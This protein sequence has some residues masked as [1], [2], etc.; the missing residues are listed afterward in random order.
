MKIRD[1][2]LV[3]KKF[4]FANYS[5]F[6][7]NSGY[8][9][10]HL[11]ITP[12]S[13]N[14]NESFERI[15]FDYENV[16]KKENLSKDS[17]FFSR[18]HFDNKDMDVKL[19]TDF[20]KKLSLKPC[21]VIQQPPLTGKICFYSW[22]IY[23]KKEKI[24]HLTDNNEVFIQGKNYD[25]LFNSGIKSKKNNVYLQTKDIFNQFNKRLK[26][27][28]MNFNNNFVRSWIYVADI[29]ENYESMVKARKDFFYKQGLKNFFPASTGI[30]C[31]SS[32]NSYVN[33]DF[34]SVNRIKKEQIVPI[35]SRLMPKPTLY[36]VTFERG[37]EIIFGDRK[38]I[39]ISG[40]ASIGK[41]GEVLYPDNVEKQTKVIV[42]NIKD[43]LLSCNSS[44]NDIAQMNV[45]LRNKDDYEK[46]KKIIDVEFLKNTPYLILQ[47]AVCRKDWL[48]EIDAIAIK[49]IKSKFPVLL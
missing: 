9:E 14:L 23:S 12:N 49:S 8:N 10:L 17:L 19:I 28:K 31:L 5:V 46:V 39:Y 29:D 45:Y 47:G 36:G 1:T 27:R 11:T 44:L 16:L 26:N 38:H 40:T 15:I 42:K 30:G 7:S 2:S 20:I 13:Y 3:K 48:V 34:F 37:L 41:K 43:L 18:I 32:D 21:S 24:F 33:A 4:G 22:H 35:S 6:N 25:L